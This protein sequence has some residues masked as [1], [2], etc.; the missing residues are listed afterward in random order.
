M[1][2]PSPADAAPD[3]E[4]L[5][6]LYDRSLLLDRCAGK[7]S[8]TQEGALRLSLMRQRLLLSMRA[9]GLP[10]SRWFRL[11]RRGLY[12]E[13]ATPANDAAPPYRLHAAPWAAVRRA[14]AA[15]PPEATLCRIQGGPTDARA[16][17]VAALPLVF[18]AAPVLLWYWQPALASAL[19]CLCLLI[20]VAYVCSPV[21]RSAP[22]GLK[23]PIRGA[24]RP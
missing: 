9:A 14:P 20:L 24:G 17:G 19:A 16:R 13:P 1:A 7:I 15:E 21:R 2:R 23:S 6:E 5:A 10:E 22:G 8:R 3:P 4:R 18:P 12:L 11:G